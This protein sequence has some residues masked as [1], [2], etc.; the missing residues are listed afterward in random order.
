MI[1]TVWCLNSVSARLSH[2]GGLG[3]VAGVAYVAGY[4]VEES[5]MGLPEILI[6]T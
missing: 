3:A 4:A 6:T 5:V 1:S 2:L